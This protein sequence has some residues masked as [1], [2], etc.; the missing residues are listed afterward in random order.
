MPHKP[1]QLAVVSLMLL[2]AFALPVLGAGKTKITVLCNW[3]NVPAQ[4][5]LFEEI[6]AGFNRSQEAIEA[7]CTGD[8][9]SIDKLK[10]MIVAGSVPEVV[11]FDRYM[12]GQ[13]ANEGL[14]EPIEPLLP[15]DL[16]LKQDFFPATVEEATLRGRLYAMPQTT[17]IRGLLWNQDLLENAGIDS[18]AAPHSW[19]EFN[20]NARKL[21][22]FDSHNTPTQLG[23]IPWWGNWG[24]MGWFWHFGG[25]YYDTATGKLTLTRRENIAA[26]AWMQEYARD[27]GTPSLLSAAGFTG[28]TSILVANGKVAMEVAHYGTVKGWYMPANPA[29][30]A[31]GSA[32]PYPVG[33]R[34]GTWSGGM[35]FVVP[36]GAKY[37]REAGEFLAY[38]AKPETQKI[39][40][41]GTQDVPPNR[42]A[43]PLII[44]AMDPLERIFVDQLAVTNW[45][46]PFTGI[47]SSVVGT[48]QS[49]ILELQ[50]APQQALE[51]A[52]AALLAQY[53]DLWK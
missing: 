31:W 17:D 1:L 20:R 11:H 15:R 28:N 6:I 24:W 8:G 41:L 51:E 4:V 46:R 34:N 32:L 50:K 19:E 33:G 5:E 37:P 42:K 35:S 49:A 26:F 27:F 21:T 39:W 14:L 29:M 44:D 43:I 53:P 25:D 2:V 36:V 30:R 18:T 7:V 23:F 40:Y 52:Q 13:L 47:I 3:Y 12:V 45:R 16:N 22:R 10:T 48:A 38:I 9:G